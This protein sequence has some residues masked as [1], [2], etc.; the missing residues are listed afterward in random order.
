MFINIFTESWK[1]LLL[2]AP[3][4]MIGL[5]AATIIKMYVPDSLIYKHLGGKGFKSVIKAAVFGI[6]L[7]ICSCGVIPT[8]EG[9][10]SQGA[11]KGATTSFLISTPET[12]VDSIAVT[13]SLLGPVMAVVRVIASFITA[14]IAGTLVSYVQDN[15][16]FTPPDSCSCSGNTNKGLTA[17]IYDNFMDVFKPI[18]NWMTAGILIGGI[19]SA[20]IPADFF[21]NYLGSGLSG[22]LIMLLVSVPIYVC[23]SGSTP[24]AAAL[25]LKGISPGTALVFLLAGPATNAATLTVLLKILG[26]K[27]T[28]VYLIS[29]VIVSLCLGLIVDSIDISG[30]INKILDNGLADSKIGIISYTTGIILIILALF[31]NFESFLKKEKPR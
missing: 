15:T 29:L 17:K 5:V 4:I 9:L 30:Y 31:A 20:V 16:K 24:I 7:P 28:F 6:P 12:G 10:R 8:A 26:K 2:S 25:I 14:V 22:M 19:I 27:E 1:L 3:Y 21:N 18:A 23:A 13:Y 11:G